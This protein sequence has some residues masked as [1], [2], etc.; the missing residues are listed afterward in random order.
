MA[1]NV[2]SAGILAAECDCGQVHDADHV[3]EHALVGGGGV[4]GAPRWQGLPWGYPKARD[5]GVMATVDD[6]LADRRRLDGAEGL[7]RVEDNLYD[8]TPFL[9]RHPGGREWLQLT[10][11]TDIT[12]V[13]FA[14][15]VAE[16]AEALLPKFLA[17]PATAPRNSPFTFHR[18]GFYMQLR[19]RVRKV[20]DDT[21]KPVLEAAKQRSKTIVDVLAA[22]ALLTCALAGYFRSFFVLGTVAG[23]L[24]SVTA[25][26]AHNFFHQKHNWR[27]FY[28]ELS[29]MSSRE[30]M[31]SH[32]LS[33]HIFPNTLQDLEVTFFEPF[34]SFLPYPS[35]HLVVRYLSWGY[36]VVMYAVLGHGQFGKR[37]LN[38]RLEPTDAVALAVPASVLLAGTP[39]L[40]AWLLWSWVLIVSSFYFGYQ[41]LSA[42]HH[43][44]DNY[45]EGDALGADHDF[46]L[47]QLAA[48]STCTGLRGRTWLLL[49]LTHF[50]DHRLHH[51]FPALDHAVLPLLE[52]ALDEHLAQY[53][54][55]NVTITSWEALRGK[56]L[57]M[58]R[59]RPNPRPAS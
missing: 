15:H 3:H 35:K 50:G 37:L 9:D 20:L 44:P 8:L 1:P 29:F 26:A 48:T 17:R 7:W 52:P 22:S 59:N 23:I 21:P 13:F 27:R 47:M 39:L 10:R 57:Q 19:E 2:V 42:G 4:A 18:D 12:E 5:K 46:G 38:L 51:M 30:W 53:R 33:H 28:F 43:H 24:V 45:H 55:P 49:T 31:V 25:S 36:S 16:T 6:W 54:L 32:A 58:A 34:V 14:H 40:D 11:G 41:G 56:Y